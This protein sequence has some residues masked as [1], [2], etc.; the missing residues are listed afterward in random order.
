MGFQFKTRNVVI[1]YGAFNQESGQR[2]LGKDRLLLIGPQGPIHVIS[3]QGHA[4]GQRK[5]RQRERGVIKGPQG[6]FI[7]SR[8]GVP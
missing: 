6:T 1:T 2:A 4:P 3:I 8:T 7:Y 5:K